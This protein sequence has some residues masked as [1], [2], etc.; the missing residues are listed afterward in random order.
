MTTIAAE[1]LEAAFPRI[2]DAEFAER[3]RNLKLKMAGHNIDLLVAYSNSLDPG[4][5][6]YFSDVC[7]IN[8]A[9]ALVVAANGDPVVCSGPASQPGP[10]TRRDSERFASFPKLGRWPRQSTRSGKWIPWR[11]C[12]GSWPANKWCG[13]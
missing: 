9:A 4:H 5:V 13:R 3:L 6:R 12:S 11:I 7:G 1:T 8:E 10:R 2:P